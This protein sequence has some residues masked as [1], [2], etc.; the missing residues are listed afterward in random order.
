MWKPFASSFSATSAFTAF[1]TLCVP[2]QF[3]SS[4]LVYPQA[5]TPMIFLF[6]LVRCWNCFWNS[7]WLWHCRR[8][9][10]FTLSAHFALW[11]ANFSHCYY[12]IS[13]THKGS[14][15]HWPA[16]GENTR[17]ANPTASNYKM[18]NIVLGC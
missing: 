18:S 10:I 1:T 6:P 12:P 2:S 16:R 17:S 11:F 5:Q 15:G 7:Y 13:I 9:L 8:R 4:S 3:F 14:K